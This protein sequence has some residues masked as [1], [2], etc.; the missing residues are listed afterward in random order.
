MPRRV[1]YAAGYKATTLVMSFACFK[2]HCAI[3]A[4]HARPLLVHSVTHISAG[5]SRGTLHSCH[6]CSTVGR[7]PN[8]ALIELTGTLKRRFTS[9][10]IGKPSHTSEKP[11]RYA[12]GSAHWCS[13]FKTTPFKCR[14]FYLF[15]YSQSH[16]QNFECERSDSKVWHARVSCT[17]SL[18]SELVAIAGKRSDDI[19]T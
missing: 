6:A 1:R 10:R 3:A 11:S 18:V 19:N 13:L 5:L 15:I 12:R 17:A 14:H 7:V 8:I 9:G 2:G 16:F 4:P